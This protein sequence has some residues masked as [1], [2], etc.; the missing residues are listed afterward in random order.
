MRVRAADVPRGLLTSLACH[1][2]LHVPDDSQ[3]AS[4]SGRRDPRSRHLRAASPSE[5]QSPPGQ[6]Q[7]AAPTQ[8][9]RQA[10]SQ[11]PAPPQPF[12]TPGRSELADMRREIGKMRRG[13]P[14][15]VLAIGWP[16]VHT[17]TDKLYSCSHGSGRPFCRGACSWMEPPP[18]SF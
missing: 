12:G 5:Q 4:S 16:A 3:S 13:L 9:Q 10:R 7:P 11:Q 15:Q 18:L 2:L 14:R 1:E 6:G 17:A 8:S